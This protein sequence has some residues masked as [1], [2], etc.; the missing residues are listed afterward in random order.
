[1]H[2]SSQVTSLFSQMRSDDHTVALTSKRKLWHI[3]RFA[4]RPGASQERAEIVAQLITLLGGDSGSTI[5]RELVWMLSEIGGDESVDPIAALLD[6]L[7]L[8][9][10]ARMA[11]QRIPGDQSLAA[12]R[13][14]LAAAPVDFQ[15]NLVQS[16]RGRGVTVPGYP[17]KKMVPT[18]RTMVKPIG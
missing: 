6:D 8:R 1:M 5:R 18:K 4:G 13:E 17:C 15:A 10:D 11:L 3:V 9:E 14:G 7:A 2:D 16:L 12:L